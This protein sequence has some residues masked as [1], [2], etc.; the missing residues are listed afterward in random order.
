[1]DSTLT[2]LGKA[3]KTVN[4]VGVFNINLLGYESD[5]ETND[6]SLF[7]SLYVTTN[8]SHLL[9]CNSY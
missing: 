9:K 2:K 7:A 5:S 8:K 6:F 3:N 1:M 4:V